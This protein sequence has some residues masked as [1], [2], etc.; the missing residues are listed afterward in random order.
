MDT[1]SVSTINTSNFPR[2]SPRSKSK[3]TKK[4]NII[5]P[6]APMLKAKIK[7]IALRNRQTKW[8]R[9]DPTLSLDTASPSERITPSPTHPAKMFGFPNKEFIRIPTSTGMRLA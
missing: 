1:I 4:A 5:I 3:Y 6:L 7:P 8:N 9:R 2:R